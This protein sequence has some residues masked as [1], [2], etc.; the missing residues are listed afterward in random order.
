MAMSTEDMS[1]DAEQATLKEWGEVLTALRTMR[2]N[3]TGPAK[4]IGA[5][6]E[7]GTACYQVGMKE[8]QDKATP[9][10]IMP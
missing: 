4:L 1:Q 2:A 5:I 7:Y 6:Y 8:G 9:G 3:K 10:Y